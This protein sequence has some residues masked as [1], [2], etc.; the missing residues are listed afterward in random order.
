MQSA[1]TSHQ[2]RLSLGV[3]RLDIWIGKDSA[4]RALRI[5]DALIKGLETRG[6]PVNLEGENKTSTV[7]RIHD[8]KLAFRITE[9]VNRV[10][11]ADGSTSRWWR[12]WD[13]IPTGRLALEIKERFHGQ[14]VIRDG[15]I[16]RLEDCLNRFI[17]LLV[18]SAEIM[19]VEALEREARWREY[20]IEREK[21]RLARRKRE[22]DKVR[23]EQLL[24]SAKEWQQCHSMRV[25]IDAVQENASDELKVAETDEWIT[26]A[27]Q[28]LAILEAKLLQPKL[29]SLESIST[30]SYW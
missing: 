6:F 20:E 19:K 28:K 4:K 14:K 25:Y 15:K 18:K 7:V 2:G 12:D 27:K 11:R 16:Q 8:Q 1:R 10:E 26:W 29:A 24:A 9:S 5:M 21:E 23:T 13:Y 22:L 30:H 17:L 3:D